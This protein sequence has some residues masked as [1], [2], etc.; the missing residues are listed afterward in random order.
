MDSIKA[1][2]MS[3]NQSERTAL[4]GNLHML[5]PSW[6][7]GGGAG[8]IPCTLFSSVES[9]NL[10]STGS[11]AVMI[12]YSQSC[13]YTYLVVFERETKGNWEYVDTTSLSS[14]FGKPKISFESLID[15]SA[16]DIVV[17]DYTVDDGTGINQVDMVIFKYFP[18]GLHVV[19]EAP[20]HSVYAAE[21]T[22]EQHQESTFS[23]IVPASDTA[24]TSRRQVLEKRVV[25]ERDTKLTQ[26]WLY[27]WLP[28]IRA[29]QAIRTNEPS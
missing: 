20:E 27:I 2:L 22:R 6:T 24:K 16:K 4:A 1:R 13:S 23:F 11:Q 15:D 21:P 17:S 9:Q 28:E 19:L 7:R 18:G 14:K 8:T 3:G 10:S 25:Q 5:I 12:S 26:W 29:F